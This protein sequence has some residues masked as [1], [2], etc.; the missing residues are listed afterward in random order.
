MTSTTETTQHPDVSEISDL[1]EGLLPPSRAAEVRGHVDGCALCGDVH[2]SLAEIR[3]LL[4]TVPAPQHMPDDV[5][6]RLDAALAA[7][8][9]STTAS[10]G[11]VPHVSRETEPPVAQKPDAE[12]SLSDRPA[13]HPRATT[14]P[15]RRSARRRRRTAV[16]GTALGAAVVG[17]SVFMLQNVQS[18]SQEDASLKAADHGSSSAPKGTGTFTASTLEGRVQT[19]L[20]SA[21]AK[22]SSP[23]GTDAEKQAPPS[24][25]IQSTPKSDSPGSESPQAPLRAP[26][27]SVP[28]CV[29]QGI[30]RK[31][32]ALA[33]E[34]GT[35]EG[36]DAFLVVLPHPSDATRV[37]AYVVDAACVR[38]KSAAKAE[39]LLTHAYA[40]P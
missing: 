37:Q 25:D 6:D 3:D 34:E 27:V 11:A 13:G 4:G 10:V 40:R 20:L 2:A 12:P 1:T 14:G 18:S 31:T 15:G 17:V 23:D 32:A 21:N 36:T 33:M 38:E 9:L 29:E 24:V 16:L 35:Y 39:L 5:V 28:L 30:G 22:S 19:L 8:A 26:A 7:E